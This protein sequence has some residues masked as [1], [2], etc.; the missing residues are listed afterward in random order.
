[1]RTNFDVSYGIEVN[2]A[3]SEHVELS[4]NILIP[5][6]GKVE[7]YRPKR[8]Y[9]KMSDYDLMEIIRNAK[10]VLEQRNS[11]AC[12]YAKSFRMALGY[13]NAEVEIKPKQ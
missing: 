6:T 8:I 7:E 13:S 9:V 3:S 2:T 1:M 4:F 12:S 11:N 10:D 5:V